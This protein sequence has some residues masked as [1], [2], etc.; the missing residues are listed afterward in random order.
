[1]LL[2]ELFCS[3]DDYHRE[4]KSYKTVNLRKSSS[5]GGIILAAPSQETE[6]FNAAMSRVI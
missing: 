2:L 3:R 4:L 5:N 1:M 6:Y